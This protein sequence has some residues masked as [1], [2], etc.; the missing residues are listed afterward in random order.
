MK[1]RNQTAA[2]GPTNRSPSR[3]AV[4][5]EKIGSKPEERLSGRRISDDEASHNGEADQSPGISDGIAQARQPAHLILRHQSRHH[6]VGE[7]GREL[8]GC[9]RHH[10]RRQHQTR[11]LLGRLPAPLAK[12]R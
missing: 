6:G 9:G 12:A 1:T 3:V 4:S 8:D 5:R 10:E 11:S 2:N 7:Y